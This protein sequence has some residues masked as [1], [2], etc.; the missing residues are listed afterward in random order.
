VGWVPGDKEHVNEGEIVENRAQERFAFRSR[1][2]DGTYDNSFTLEP[3]GQRTKVTLRLDFVNMKGMAAFAVPMLF[4][5][6]GKKDLRPRMC[7]LKAKAE[8]SQG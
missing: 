4:P 2:K 1:D 8:A 7:L 6:I 5:L 3:Q